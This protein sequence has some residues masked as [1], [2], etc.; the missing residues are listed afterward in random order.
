MELRKELEMA[1]MQYKN[2]LEQLERLKS[3]SDDASSLHVKDKE[4][5]EAHVAQLIAL[6]TFENKSFESRWKER[7]EKYGVEMQQQQQRYES[8]L[9]DTERQLSHAKEQYDTIISTLQSSQTGAHNTHHEIIKT[10]HG[11]LEQ[12]QKEYDVLSQN[13]DNLKSQYMKLTYDMEQCEKQRKEIEG[14]YTK[15]GEQFAAA[16][17]QDDQTMLQTLAVEKAKRAELKLQWSQQLLQYKQEKEKSKARVVE[18]ENE[19]AELK[20]HLKSQEDTIQLEHLKSE[21]LQH[22]LHISQTELSALQSTR[23]RNIEEQKLA[24]DNYRVDL[25]EKQKIIDKMIHERENE[26]KRW[27]HELEL[28]LIQ[29][30]TIH[31]NEKFQFEK[32]LTNIRNEMDSIGKEHEMDVVNLKSQ[33]ES[34]KRQL[35][36]DQEQQMQLKIQEIKEAALTREAFEKQLKSMDRNNIY[37]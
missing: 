6:Q 3:S 21:E 37:C 26:S 19:N 29:Q 22:K 20:R 2:C 10:H 36:R 31:H 4:S 8:K 32:E 14:K 7:E 30:K 25:Y 35:L 1:Q 5:L 11:Q 28:R 9:Q 16:L 33:F 17:Q 23:D 15:I 24:Y 27:H 13:H 18:I 34:E 12:K